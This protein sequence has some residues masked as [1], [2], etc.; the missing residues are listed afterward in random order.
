MIKVNITT[1]HSSFADANPEWIVREK[2]GRGTWIAEVINCPDYSGH[3]SAFTTEQI[4]RSIGMTNFWGKLADAGAKFY[5]GLTVGSIVHYNSGFNSFVR[6][7]VMEDK[8]LL[9]IA[10]VGNW[11]SCDL[12]QRMNDGSI[13]D[14]YHVDKIKKGTVFQPNASNIY[15]YTIL[16]KKGSQPI[17]FNPDND[18]RNMIPLTFDVPDMTPEQSK[19]AAKVSLVNNIQNICGGD[20]T[21]DEKLAMIRSLL[22]PTAL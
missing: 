1:F 11:Q 7:K 20:M 10:L 5:A 4:E 14:G 8:Q 13:Y 2:R 3:R 17:G 9:P 6:C 18:P 22:N 12:P 19:A 21:P 15:E 16:Q